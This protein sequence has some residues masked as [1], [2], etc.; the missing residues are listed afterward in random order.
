MQKIAVLLSLFLVVSGLALAQRLPEIAS[1][2]N[3]QLT[4]SPDFDKDSFAGDEIIQIR[5][6]KPTSTITLNAVEIDFKQVTITAGGR[7]QPAKVALNKDKQMATLSF[8]NQ[9]S[10]G[11]ASIHILYTGIL[12]DEL[13]GFYLSKAG[14]RKYAVTQ[15]EATDARR[16]F[17]SFDEPA[18][19]ATFDITAVVDKG[20][21]AISNAPVA[22]DTPGPGG[23]KHTVK[24]ETSPKMSSYLVALAVGDFE[25]V[26]GSADGIPIRVWATPGKK[27]M[28]RFSLAAAEQCMKYYDQYFGI[29]YPFKKL[30][31]IGL[32][33][34]AAGAM[35]N[36]GAI[37][38]RDVA[39][40]VDEND[41]PTSAKKEV[42]EVVAHEMAHMWFGDLVTMA[43][44]DDIW[45]NE[46]FATWMSSKPIESWRPDWNINLDD[47]RDTGEALNLD[48]LQNTRPI[49]QPADTPA[50]IQELFDGIAYTKTA[51]VL[52]MLESYLGEERFKAGVNAYLQ[53]H[54]YGNATQTDFWSALAKASDK[55]VDKIMPTF[56]DQPGA[57][58]VSVSSQCDG[59]QTKVTLAQHRFFYDKSLLQAGNA[60]LWQIPIFLKGAKGEG[61]S[62]LLTSAEQ[63]FSVPQCDSWVFANANGNGYYRIKYDSAVFNQMTQNA[64]KDFSP[65]ERIVLVRDAWAAVRAGQQPIGDFL[66]LADALA[67]D[68]NSVVVRQMNRELDYIGDYLVS[69]S[70]R[71]QYQAWVRGLLN[72]VLKDV[73]WQPAP[74]EDENRKALRANVLYTL[75]YAGRDQEVLSRAR[76]LAGQGLRNPSAI[77]A[78]IVDAVF[79]LAALDGSSKFY[80]ELMADLKSANGAP[81]Q[82][83]RYLF[84]LADFTNP[85]LLQKTLQFA[86]SPEVRSQDSLILI[87]AV[88]GNPSGEKLAWDY[89]QSHWQAINKIMGG[90][91][92][93]GLVQT[94]GSFCDPQLRNQVR[95][96][97]T[98]HPVADAERSFRQ[99]QESSAYCIDLRASQAPALASWLGQHGSASGASR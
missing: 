87:A 18:Y 56:V 95:D 77:D 23:G 84:T 65:A 69:D 9:L 35:E 86:L 38:F 75:G 80:D 73:G 63:A 32:P 59:E 25:Y 76:E 27:E 30:D 61:N 67:T 36:T 48:S 85:E 68:R 66:H 98:Q 12:N 60:E 15:F 33:D 52:R 46:G 94:T 92:T 19:K 45:L 4:F 28:G 89:V 10:A 58:L 37:T 93:G 72:P 91:N 51:A 74:G 31:L 7:Q 78:S 17:P 62:Q 70:D 82:Y 42:A 43:W 49:H 14:G 6:L 55:P 50:Q 26:E 34:F 81:Q 29:K 39:L 16:A 90:Y 79:S 20:D 40:L 96:F 21:V 54:A 97:F 99:A 64:E 5:V 1:P 71:A 88:M 53:A 24:F 41:A 8:A 47:V 13:R 11:N 2:D 22:S 57:P 3:Y 83:Y 44:W